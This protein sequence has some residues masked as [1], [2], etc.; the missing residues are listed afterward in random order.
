[1]IVWLGDGA[2]MI[3]SAD[4]IRVNCF[5]SSRNR[6]GGCAP[7][8]AELRWLNEDLEKEPKKRIEP[9]SYR[10]L[11]E[12][13]FQY[14]VVGKGGNEKY[15]YRW[16]WPRIERLEGEYGAARLA[17]ALAG[18]FLEMVSLH[19]GIDCT[20]R[21]K[22]ALARN[23][24]DIGRDG[25][26]IYDEGARKSVFLTLV[27][28]GFESFLHAYHAAMSRPYFDDRCE[29]APMIADYASFCR[30]VEDADFRGKGMRCACRSGDSLMM[31][32][33]KRGGSGLKKLKESVQ[34]LDLRIPF[35]DTG[36][37]QEERTISARWTG[38]A[39]HLLSAWSQGEV[40]KFMEGHR[41]S[42]RWFALW[43]SRKL[44]EVAIEEPDPTLVFLTLACFYL[45]LLQEEEW[46]VG[47]VRALVEAGVG[48]RIELRLS[49]C[50]L[51]DRVASA[52]LADGAD[53][54]LR[55]V[56]A[57]EICDCADD[58]WYE[59][60][61]PEEREEELFK[62]LMKDDTILREHPDLCRMDEREDRE[63]REW[64]A[65]GAPMIFPGT[66]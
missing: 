64:L 45:E 16:A 47:L 48:D 63:A 29:G 54:L 26:R 23:G 17:A 49:V 31:L 40:G 57:A 7:R 20:K 50:R 39:G 55:A 21:F 33:Y 59:K 14:A 61:G 36:A 24:M 60:S 42:Y 51:H 10:D 27:E 62:L 12:N 22:N 34:Q 6:T 38:R 66:R 53:V 28:S 9:Y 3:D 18:M 56:R 15:F 5:G 32:Y 52:L 1:M 58:F 46:A 43:A 35:R 30:F 37:A 11:D 8:D 65:N 19:D 2:A 13:V 4:V 25:L 44:G 41:G